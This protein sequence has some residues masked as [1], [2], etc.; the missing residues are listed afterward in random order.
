LD[1]RTYG[2]KSVTCGYALSERMDEQNKNFT[3]LSNFKTQ[4]LKTTIYE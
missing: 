4:F 2:I 3:F 1:T